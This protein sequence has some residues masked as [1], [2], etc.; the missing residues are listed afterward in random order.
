[1][2]INY[3]TS[4]VI[5]ISGE[6]SITFYSGCM[7]NDWNSLPNEAVQAPDVESFKTKLDL[8]WN[9]TFKLKFMQHL[10]INGQI[11]CVATKAIE[12]S[13]LIAT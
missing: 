8:F 4:F 6:E 2:V 3:S 13:Y 1:M 9:L 5:L 11:F 7:V 12:G 10:K